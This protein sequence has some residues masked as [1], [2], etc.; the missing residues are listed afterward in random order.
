MAKMLTQIVLLSKHVMGSGSKAV[1][2][3]GVSGV[4]PDDA[5]FEALFNE[6][7]HFLANQRGGFCPNYPRQAGTNVGIESVMKVGEIVI[8]NGVTVGLI[9]RSGMTIRIVV[10]PRMSAKSQRSKGL[11]LKI[12][13]WRI[14][15][16]VFSTKWKGW[17]KC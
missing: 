10:Y 13:A 6:K 12:F 14:C 17:T 4:N 9:G 11:I 8:G 2:T 1:N 7:V 16:H 3:V 5:H 15:L